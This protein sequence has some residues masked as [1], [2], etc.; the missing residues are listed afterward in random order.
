MSCI[1]N[2]FILA[3]PKLNDTKV[4]IIIQQIKI[5]IHKLKIYIFF[6]PFNNILK[7]SN[8]FYLL[9]LNKIYLFD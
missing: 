8:L 1:V 6:F 2:A 7:G 3:N 9:N 5:V 4:I